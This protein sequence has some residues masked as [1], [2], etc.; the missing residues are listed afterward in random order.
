MTQ[1]R[2]VHRHQG[3][4]ITG[5]VVSDERGE[6]VPRIHLDV[7]N[8]RGFVVLLLPYRTLRVAKGVVDRFVRGLG[9]DCSIACERWQDR[10]VTKGVSS[11]QARGYPRR[12]STAH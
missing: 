7:P 12:L 6:Y 2:R 3:G 11:S 4:T 9:H 1:Y 10:A 8:Q 5:V